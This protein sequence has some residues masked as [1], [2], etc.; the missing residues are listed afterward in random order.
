[1]SK[2]KQE[3]IRITEY[4]NSHFTEH[5]TVQSVAQALYMDRGKVSGLFTKCAGI[6]LN[7]YINI[8][9]LERADQL[10]RDGA[11]IT[12]AALECGFQSVRTFNDIYKKMNG[13]APSKHGR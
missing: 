4:V 7:A 8:L 6:T 2:D 9:R 10:I 13:T 1:M 3:F 11:G 5:L 12:Q